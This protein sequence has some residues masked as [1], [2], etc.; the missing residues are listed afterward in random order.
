VAI[1]GP[2]LDGELPEAGVRHDLANADANLLRLTAAD[3]EPYLS[4]LE[5]HPSEA[6]MLVAAAAMGVVGQ[7]EIRDRGSLVPLRETS[8]DVYLS[9]ADAILSLNAVAQ[10]LAATQSFDEAEAATV[11][12]CGRSELDHERRKA[13]TLAHN[14]PSDPSFDELRS[15]FQD[16]RGRA[17]QRGVDFVSFRRLTEVIGRYRYDVHAM[18]ALVGELAYRRLPLCRIT[19]A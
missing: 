15:R 12:I 17:A 6:T 5:H 18:R 16:Y 8:A 19:A 2:G 13:E 14:R 3:V 11:A 1:A 7:A 10:K 9:A 4:V